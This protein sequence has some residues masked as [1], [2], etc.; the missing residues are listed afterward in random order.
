MMTFPTEWTNK[1]HVPVTT[2]ITI[3]ITINPVLIHHH[4]TI[5]ITITMFQSPPTSYVSHY[6]RVATV[7]VTDGHSSAV[8]DHKI[9]RVGGVRRSPSPVPK[10]F[11]KY[12]SSIGGHY[13]CWCLNPVFRQTH[14]IWISWFDPWF[15]T[16]SRIPQYPL[17]IPLQ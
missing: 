3:F 16:I 6:Q 5:F 2:N 17:H 12:S 13:F 7:K 15:S 9:L 14:L 8:E 10:K 11:L 4:T 1:S